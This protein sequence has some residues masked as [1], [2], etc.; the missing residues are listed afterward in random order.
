MET[1]DSITVC[2]VTG[3]PNIS[4]KWNWYDGW[5]ITLWV[6]VGKQS[7]GRNVLH[8]STTERNDVKEKIG[9]IVSSDFWT[10]SRKPVNQLEKTWENS[11]MKNC[12]ESSSFL[13]YKAE[14]SFAPSKLCPA[15]LSPVW[16]ATCRIVL[17]SKTLNVAKEKSTV[18]GNPQF[19][20][21]RRPSWW[22]AWNTKHRS[23]HLL[24]HH[25]HRHCHRRHRH[26]HRHPHHHHHNHHHHHHHV[27]P[28]FTNPG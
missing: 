19:R 12:Q 6:S 11:K 28:R 3:I 21:P 7:R 20:L 10:N 23:H 14:T 9:Q 24:S 15:C 5:R 27:V 26:R 18:G 22:W 4:S 1:E 8:F 25:R 13:L 2:G 17:R 16:G